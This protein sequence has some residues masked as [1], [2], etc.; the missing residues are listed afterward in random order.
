MILI[1]IFKVFFDPALFLNLEAGVFL[2]TVIK[3][4][5]VRLLAFLETSIKVCKPQFSWRETFCQFSLIHSLPISRF[6]AIQA[7]FFSIFRL[8][9]ILCESEQ[10]C[11]LPTGCHDGVCVEICRKF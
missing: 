7:S 4:F 5:R 2:L 6:V 11:K 1:D 10:S 8:E 3:Q 9:K